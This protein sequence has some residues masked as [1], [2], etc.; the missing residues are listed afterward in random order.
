MFLL[1]ILGSGG[2]GG[3]RVSAAA[4]RQTN[5]RRKSD[6]AYESGYASKESA[7]GSISVAE[8]RDVEPETPRVSVNLS[9]RARRREKKESETPRTARSVDVDHGRQA[10][11]ERPSSAGRRSA[12]YAQDIMD[13][14]A[15]RPKARG[16]LAGRL[17]AQAAEKVEAK[18]RE[19]KI[20]KQD[21]LPEDSSSSSGSELE[22]VE[23]VVKSQEKESRRSEKEINHFISALDNTL[24]A[25]QP[26]GDG[27]DDHSEGGSS[28]EAMTPVQE[29]DEEEMQEEED[30]VSP[31][32]PRGVA[33]GETYVKPKA[34]YVH[35]PRDAPIIHV[36]E[37]TDESVKNPGGQVRT[38]G[39]STRLMDRITV[40]RKDCI[41]GLGVQKLKEAYD[42]LDNVDGEE[43]ESS[44]IALLGKVDFDIY[45]GKIW[46]LKFC[47]EAAFGLI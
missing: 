46:Q 25:N 20:Y 34:R 35:G 21:S 47:E 41:R 13:G 39:T 6:G 9:A 23:N 32:P 36:P 3:P 7:S 29:E 40:L 24:N 45:A 8:S 17:A 33:V 16:L 11:L 15:P 26:Q 5:A 12:D 18:E 22:E 1:C 27:G 19:K 4:S 38:L 14:K 42:I 30:Q 2:E 44:L 28:P 43:L 31:L 37:I 10:H